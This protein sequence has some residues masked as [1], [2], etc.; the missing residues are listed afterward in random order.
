MEVPNAFVK[1]DTFDGC[2]SENYQK[3]ACDLHINSE[4]EII[5]KQNNSVQ[6]IWMLELQR[7]K[8]RVRRC[9]S[10]SL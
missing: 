6:T 1:S 3:T 9:P 8:R 2:I 10:P 4:K 7:L 5:P